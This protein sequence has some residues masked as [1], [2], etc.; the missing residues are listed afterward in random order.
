MPSFWDAMKI[1]YRTY[2]TM[3][4]LFRGGWSANRVQTYMSDQGIGLRRTTVL[5]TRRKVLGVMKKEAL[6][7]RLPGNQTPSRN[8]LVEDD[9]GAPARYQIWGEIDA[10]NPDTGQTERQFFRQYESDLLTKDEYAERIIDKQNQGSSYGV[11]IHSNVTIRQ[12]AH[13]RGTSY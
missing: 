12:I 8:D 7:K 10:Y 4:S 3:E 13:L 5:A 2:T 6:V 1:T 9:W 11:P